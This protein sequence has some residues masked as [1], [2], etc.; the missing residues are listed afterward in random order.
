VSGSIVLVQP[1]G[2]DD[3]LDYAKSSWIDRLNQI[4]LQQRHKL[5]GVIKPP[6][7]L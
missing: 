6:V 1:L 3:F 4:D 5:Y 2:F 7:I